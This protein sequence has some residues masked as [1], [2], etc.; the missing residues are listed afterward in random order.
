MDRCIKL[1]VV[2]VV[3]GSSTVVDSVATKLVNSNL[4]LESSF[5]VSV[6]SRPVRRPSKQPALAAAEHKQEI[7][8]L[9]LH[10][11]L[12]A[13]WP[14]TADRKQPSFT[15]A[16]CPPLSLSL[17]DLQSRIIDCCSF[18]PFS[19]REGELDLFIIQ[20]VIPIFLY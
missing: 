16:F 7:S 5:P 13:W 6:A 8:Y 3:Q 20:Q 12:Q 1:A 17:S 15:M 18:I 19:L 9:N 14:Q 2:V 11:S 10:L 4:G